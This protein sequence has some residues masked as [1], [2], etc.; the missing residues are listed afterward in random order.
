MPLLT[1]FTN[2]KKANVPESTLFLSEWSLSA[3]PPV[4]LSITP[5]ALPP[6]ISVGSP[7]PKLPS[8]GATDAWNLPGDG[9]PHPRG[10]FTSC[11]LMVVVGCGLWFSLWWSPLGT[12]WMSSRQGKLSFSWSKQPWDHSS[13]KSHD[14]TGWGLQ[15][16][17]PGHKD[18]GGSHCRIVFSE[19][20]PWRYSKK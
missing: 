6:A 2:G 19:S 14:P 18:R 13:V 20:R 7:F 11:E 4:A 1:S 16:W 9:R 10:P 8:A 5:F 12:T 3:C 15:E 17:T